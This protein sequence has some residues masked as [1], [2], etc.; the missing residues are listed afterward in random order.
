MVA[1]VSDERNGMRFVYDARD[2]CLTFEPTTARAQT[3]RQAIAGRN[4]SDENIE[5]TLVEMLSQ[6]DL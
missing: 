5:V 2:A 6:A 4:V 1:Q 3:N